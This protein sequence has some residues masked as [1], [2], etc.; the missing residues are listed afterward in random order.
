MGLKTMTA[1]ES[2][3]FGILDLVNNE[4]S[5]ETIRE[6]FRKYSEGIIICPPE[7]INDFYRAIV[8]LNV[9]LREYFDNVLEKYILSFKRTK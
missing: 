1:E 9:K 7:N 5:K 2:K 8:G 4:F 3:G 6:F